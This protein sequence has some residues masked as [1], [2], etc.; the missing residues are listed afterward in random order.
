MVTSVPGR[1]S[2]SRLPGI[3]CLPCGRS[4][5]DWGRK[6]GAHT[7]L[8][9]VAI[10]LHVGTGWKLIDSAGHCTSN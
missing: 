1:A 10:A 5:R 8:E 9:A 3:D 4:G 7:R 6:L 2:D